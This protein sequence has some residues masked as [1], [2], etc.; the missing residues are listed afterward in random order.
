MSTDLF[1]SI[2]NVVSGKKFLK[3]DETPTSTS[4]GTGLPAGKAFSLGFRAHETGKKFEANP[5]AGKDDKSSVAW[6][7]GWKRSEEMTVPEV[8][9]DVET[10]DDSGAED[11]DIFDRKSADVLAG[12]KKDEGKEKLALKD[13][14]PYCHKNVKDCKCPPFEDEKGVEQHNRYGDRLGTEE[15]EVD[16]DCGEKQAMKP[17]DEAESFKSNQFAF[18]S[19]VGKDEIP[20]TVYAQYAPGEENV[21]RTSTGSSKPGKQVA[22]G[23]DEDIEIYKISGPQHGRDY[24][25]EFEYEIDRLKEEALEVVKENKRDSSIR[26]SAVIDNKNSA[27]KMSFD[28][29]K[30]KFGNRYTLEHVPAWAKN[31]FTSSSGEK[32]FYAP[33]YKS[34]QEWYDNTTFP[35]HNNFSKKDCCSVKASWP[36]G[37][38]LKAPLSGGTVTEATQSKIS[39][40]AWQQ[41]ISG[42]KMVVEQSPRLSKE[43]RKELIGFLEDASVAVSTNDL[44]LVEELIKK[45]S[46]KYGE[47]IYRTPR[48][49]DDGMNESSDDFDGTL[50]TNDAARGPKGKQFNNPDSATNELAEAMS[51]SVYE[52]FAKVLK[53]AKDRSEG[54]ST[55]LTTIVELAKDIAEIFE[56]DNHNFDIIRFIK[57]CG[58]GANNDGTGK[59][60]PEDSQ[61]KDIYANAGNEDDQ[62]G[63]E[64][65][66]KGVMKES[67]DDDL[68]NTTPIP[69]GNPSPAAPVDYSQKSISDLASII[70]R[71]WRKQGKGVNFAAKPYLDAM[72]SMDF[73]NDNY[74]QDSGKSIV[75]Y[76]LGNA[77]A[78][79]G[80]VA[81][82]VKLELK[83]RLKS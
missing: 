23:H 71:D 55:A 51:K 83:K 15:E 75:T 12:Q 31:E 9:T 38:W 33:Q 39:T 13:T 76:F 32:K 62:Y 18:A 30:K 57:A 79:K 10:P 27:P 69:S 14:C 63:L 73:I 65:T 29:A 42:W 2:K 59:A 11:D 4:T 43:T 47:A 54:D 78:W 82:T 68:L 5:F 3:E 61:E 36:K 6:A 66:I 67:G 77:T 17:L 50:D 35:P 8:N 41:T 7:R 1:E 25:S 48:A 22:P 28:D 60:H 80:D 64:N 20:V 56:A 74:G 21:Y 70:S 58:W 45:I 44:D 24:M 34:D 81:K 72:F 46:K 19:Y 16:E 26:E 53:D 49:T 52:K 40:G 37:K